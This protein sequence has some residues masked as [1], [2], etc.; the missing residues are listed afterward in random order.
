[1]LYSHTTCTLQF[2]AFHCLMLIVLL[3]QICTKLCV[4]VVVSLLLRP[5]LQ[6]E[7]GS[8]PSSQTPS[9]A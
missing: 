1:M 9:P 8:Q 3:V 4:S 7:C 5:P 2:G 6:C